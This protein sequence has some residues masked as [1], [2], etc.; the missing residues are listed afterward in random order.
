M[1]IIISVQSQADCGTAQHRHNR[2]RDFET[3][4]GMSWSRLAVTASR[5]Q[6]EQEAE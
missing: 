2:Q 4:Y 6:I 1:Q 3:R 5:H